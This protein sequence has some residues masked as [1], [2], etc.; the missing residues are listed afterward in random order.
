MFPVW[1]AGRRRAAGECA[2]RDWG[3]LLN[4]GLVI[5]LFIA[6]LQQEGLSAHIPLNCAS[7]LL[8]KGASLRVKVS[9]TQPRCILVINPLRGHLMVSCWCTVERN[10]HER[11][12]SFSLGG[13]SDQSG[14]KEKWVSMSSP[15]RRPKLLHIR[16]RLLSDPLQNVKHINW[17]FSVS[18]SSA[19]SVCVSVH[20]EWA[21]SAWWRAEG[22]FLLVAR[23]LGKTHVRVHPSLCLWLHLLHV[24]LH[25][26]K[27]FHC[28]FHTPSSP[29]SSVSML[30]LARC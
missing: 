12:S 18:S 3:L 9:K 28:D 25:Y 30:A 24:S 17:Y 10:A 8:C 27:F 15:P 22:L 14:C 1:I 4:W 5:L 2:D 20:A 16:T 23:S 11:F 7:L 6:L 29:H 26:V 19:L 13:T 21:V